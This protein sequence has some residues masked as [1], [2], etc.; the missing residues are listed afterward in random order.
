MGRYLRGKI[1]CALLDGYGDGLSKVETYHRKFGGPLRAWKSVKMMTGF[2]YIVNGACG[3]V[4]AGI[5]VK[6]IEGEACVRSVRGEK[7]G[8]EI[9]CRI[10]HAPLYGR[11]YEG[12]RHFENLLG[13]Q[14]ELS[15]GIREI[16]RR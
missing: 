9:A 8:D 10:E 13:L 2:Q 16:G 5:E 7:L 6:N 14:H 1:A 11:G 12:R 4:S 15:K 3:H